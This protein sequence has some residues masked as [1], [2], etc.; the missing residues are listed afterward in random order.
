MTEQKKQ[1]AETDKATPR[2]DE[3]LQNILHP[4]CDL[5]GSDMQ[6]FHC[7][8]ICAACGYQRDCSDP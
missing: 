7:R 8:L 2:K 6:E 5:C 3:L 1:S 4:K